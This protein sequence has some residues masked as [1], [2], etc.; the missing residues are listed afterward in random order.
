MA[1]GRQ[2]QN[3]ARSKITNRAFAVFAKRAAPLVIHDTFLGPCLIP[4]VGVMST[5]NN[6]LDDTSWGPG[7]LGRNS[8]W[9]RE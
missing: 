9:S 1:F 6:S 4:E 5:M 8:S 3:F 2:T 7:T